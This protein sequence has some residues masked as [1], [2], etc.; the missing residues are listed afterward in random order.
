MPLRGPILFHVKTAL[1]NICKSSNQVLL[2]THPHTHTST[3]SIPSSS[4]S[5]SSTMSNSPEITPGIYWIKNQLTGNYIVSHSLDKPGD[6][7]QTYSKPEIG[8]PPAIAFGIVP[9]V[10][11]DQSNEV[12]LESTMTHLYLGTTSGVRRDNLTLRWAKTPV[13]LWFK[14][15]NHWSGGFIIRIPPG[16]LPVERF[17]FEKGDT[18]EIAVTGDESEAGSVWFL[19][20]V[21][22]PGSDN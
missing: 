21:P 1:Q 6:V 10:S 13:S 20:P 9:I 3:Q 12:G 5:N 17:C 2:G 14:P 8:I 7:V 15:H 19:E 4:T 22:Q 11:T 16:Q 18:H